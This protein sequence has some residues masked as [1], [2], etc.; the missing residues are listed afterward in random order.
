MKKLLVLSLIAAMF[1]AGCSST[2]FSISKDYDFTRIKRIAVTDF[3][4]HLEYRNS[5][6]SVA[7]EFL[8]QLMKKG[9]KI[10]E[11]NKI[12]SILGEQQLADSNKLDPETIKRAGKILGVDAILTGS[13]VKYVQDSKTIVYFT[14]KDGNTSSQSML[15]QAEISISARLFDVESGE[16]IWS[17]SDRD[18][19]FEI[20]DAIYGVVYSLV[21]SM[22]NDVN[23]K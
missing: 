9:Y 20:S 19:G 3:S 22:K 23:T 8:T 5:G 14:D 6:D 2:R 13:V 17:G 11:R 10:V 1:L 16:V 7:D 12:N 15:Q 21:S 4:N 18:S